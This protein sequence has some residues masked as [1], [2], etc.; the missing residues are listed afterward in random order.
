MKA[1]L[2]P[3]MAKMEPMMDSRAEFD[4]MPF[5]TARSHDSRAEYLASIDAQLTKLMEDFDKNGI[6]YSPP[7]NAVPRASKPRITADGFILA[8]P[9]F[10]KP[11]IKINAARELARLVNAI[12]MRKP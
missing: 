9:E 8:E 3:K 10:S 6:P 11:N 12:S 7:K 2:S 1:K 5:R 4:M